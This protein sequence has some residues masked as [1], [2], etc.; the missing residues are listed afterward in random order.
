MNAGVWMTDTR[1][2]SGSVAERSIM[3][4]GWKRESRRMP[5]IDSEFAREGRALHLAFA[6]IVTEGISACHFI[7]DKFE[8][9]EITKELVRDKLAPAEVALDKI[10]D[11]V[12]G[13]ANYSCLTEETFSLTEVVP[14]CDRSTVDLL[15]WA[16]TTL[17][18]ADLKTGF[19]VPVHAKENYQ[20]GFYALGAEKI[21]LHDIGY[22]PF[23]RIVFAIIQP[24]PDPDLPDYTLWEVPDGWLHR[25]RV[26]LKTAY[27]RMQDPKAELVPGTWCKFCPARPKC[28]AYKAAGA[29]MIKRDVEGMTAIEL[30]ALLEQ[31]EHVKGWISALQKYAKEQLRSGAQV[32]GYK[33]VHK[34]KNREWVLHAAEIVRR[35]EQAEVDA[36]QPV[37]LKSPAMLEKDLGKARFQKLFPGAVKQDLGDLTMVPSTDPRP[38]AGGSAD[39]LVGA[40]LKGAPKLKIATPQ[41]EK[42]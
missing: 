39:R 29:A 16:G 27:Q 4:P 36:H 18:V 8:G 30:G 2:I 3:C 12:F 17:L 19:G 6:E 7:G 42:A 9:V 32:P 21:L 25:Y 34:R 10:G 11:E 20:L 33:L 38:A 23:D 15:A 41:K 13:T 28:S 1:S 24:Q 37:K 35:C 22:G 5:D 31:A 26:L 14:D 40:R